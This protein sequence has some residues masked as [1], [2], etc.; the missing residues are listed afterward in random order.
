MKCWSFKYLFLFA[1]L[2]IIT[3][4]CESN[5]NSSKKVPVIIATCDAGFNIN[6]NLYSLSPSPNQSEA[7]GSEQIV[8]DVPTNPHKQLASY[9]NGD[10]I[11]YGS[12][13][14][15]CW[16]L[17]GL[18]DW[19]AMSFPNRS[20][21]VIKNLCF[22]Q[23]GERWAFVSWEDHMIYEDIGG[24]AVAIAQ[25][26]SRLYKSETGEDRSAYMTKR[27]DRDKNWCFQTDD[28][29]VYLQEPDG[30][31]TQIGWEDWRVVTPPNGDKLLLIMTKGMDKNAKW[32]GKHD[33]KLYIEK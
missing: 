6:M 7:P 33:G 10:S 28:D 27:I 29:K 3:D 24:K 4:S 30:K 11:F 15:H 21:S 12:Q 18:L 19:H 31:I 23:E 8:L 2:Y 16:T 20:D 17:F 13:G 14:D 1:G 32:Q 9:T 26:R 22:K 5:H 25:I